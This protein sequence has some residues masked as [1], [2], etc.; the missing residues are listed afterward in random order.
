MTVAAAGEGGGFFQIVCLCLSGYSKLG[1]LIVAAFSVHEQRGF[2]ALS[3]CPETA[4]L[5]LHSL[6]IKTNCKL[7]AEIKGEIE[8]RRVL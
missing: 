7:A 5:L 6:S 2:R 1:Y 3:P 8:E 4:V